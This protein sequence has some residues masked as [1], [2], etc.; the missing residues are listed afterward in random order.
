[1]FLS[2]PETKKLL[3]LEEE[4][5]LLAQIQDLFKLKETKIKLQSQFGREPTL[6]EW[7]DGLGLSCR[8]LETRLHS[9][10]RSKDKL[11]NAGKFREF[12]NT[13]LGIS[14]KNALNI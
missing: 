9:G 7:A 4:S 14:H 6:A 11:V 1:L 5:Q 13:G 10:N 2:S 12:G 8:A 3:N